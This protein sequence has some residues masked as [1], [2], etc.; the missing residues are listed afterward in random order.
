MAN[1]QTWTRQGSG[2]NVILKH[3][4]SRDD[5]TVYI[6]H[7]LTRARTAA[8]TTAGWDNATESTPQ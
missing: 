4:G 2:G 8:E 3:Y 7:Q 6:V 1:L 5:G